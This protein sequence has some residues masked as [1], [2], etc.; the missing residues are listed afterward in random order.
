MILVTGANGFLGRALILELKARRI[1]V[2]GALRSEAREGEVSVGDIGPDT[3]WSTALSGVGTIVHT[4]AHVHV[5]NDAGDKTLQQYRR[6][7]VDGT[8]N[9]ARQAVTAGVKRFIYLSS[10]KVN[11]ETTARGKPFTAADIP[12]PQDHYAVSKYEAEKGLRRLGGEKGLEIVIIRPPL[13]YGPGVKGNFARLL[14][15][16][17]SGLPLPLD[18]IDNRRSLIALDNL[19]DLIVTCIDHPKAVDCTLLVSDGD[20]LSTTV[21]LRKLGDALDIPVRLFSIPSALLEIAA[22]LSGQRASVRR[23]TRSLQLDIT[24]T[25]EL[26]GWNPP[27]SV[28]QG[29]RRAVQTGLE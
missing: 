13:V 6:V 24:S 19:V 14:R 10:I 29:L 21:L 15:W 23:L 3:D 9:L 20:D 4:A 17:Q 1:A 16:I 28:E 5:M 26:L 7:N 11:G 25:R 12:A 2:R 22:S 27:V 8:L 18:A